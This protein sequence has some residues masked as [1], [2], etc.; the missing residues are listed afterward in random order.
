MKTKILILLSLGLLLAGCAAPTV[1]SPPQATS[2][3]QPPNLAPTSSETN[4]DQ[5]ETDITSQN[6]DAD[7]PLFTVDDLQ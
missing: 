6:I 2:P 1:I 7:F 3:T 5:E 4:L